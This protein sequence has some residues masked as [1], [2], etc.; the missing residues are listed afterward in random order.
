[1]ANLSE[2]HQ[3]ENGD[4]IEV[5]VTGDAVIRIER[6]MRSAQLL[7]RTLA[8]GPPSGISDPIDETRDDKPDAEL[9]EML[10]EHD[11]EFRAGHVTD[12][13]TIT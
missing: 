5:T 9:H 4:A 12:W 11:I 3:F 7:S 2:T 6:K 1:M 10:D 13:N 8:S